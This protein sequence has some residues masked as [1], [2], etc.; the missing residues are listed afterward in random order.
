MRMRSSLAVLLVLG[1]SPVKAEAVD[2]AATRV[3][4]LAQE[5]VWREPVPYA[6]PSRIQLKA[7]HVGSL[8][9]LIETYGSSVGRKVLLFGG[10][11]VSRGEI[12]LEEASEDLGASEI[13]VSAYGGLVSV[14]PVPVSRPIELLP[15]LTGPNADLLLQFRDPAGPVV[16]QER[17]GTAVHDKALS[18]LGHGDRAVVLYTN[19]VGQLRLVA[20]SGGRGEPWDRALPDAI[21]GAAAMSGVDQLVSVT[22]DRSPSDGKASLIA[23]LWSMNGE[24]IWMKPLVS[25]MDHETG[26]I[27]IAARGA[28]IAVM[29]FG[30]EPDSV[31]FVAKLRSSGEVV[32]SSNVPSGC[33]S[34][35]MDA[36]G[37]VSVLCIQEKGLTL[38]A[39]L[40]QSTLTGHSIEPVSCGDDEVTLVDHAGLVAAGDDEYWVGGRSSGLSTS[41]LW[42]ASVKVS[43]GRGTGNEAP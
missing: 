2:G 32:E 22:L 13:S 25:G 16:F 4:L 27:Q 5:P 29:W 7:T 15:G 17:I 24:L 18:V 38:L 41:C 33:T 39:D 19:S 43:D 23:R 14:V 3:P 36:D 35:A 28:T 42:I 20:R 11:G 8:Y 9:A 6:T 21:A 10:D 1:V 40:G 26:M 12:G 30:N 31:P 34:L 37:R